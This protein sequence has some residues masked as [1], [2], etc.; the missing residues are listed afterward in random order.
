MP[1]GFWLQLKI[2]R[3]TTENKLQVIMMHEMTVP[4]HGYFVP[5]EIRKEWSLA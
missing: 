4:F 1:V 2:N 3:S 5:S